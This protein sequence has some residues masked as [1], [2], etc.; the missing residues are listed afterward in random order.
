VVTYDEAKRRVNISKHGV[1]MSRLSGFFDGDLLTREDQREAYGEAR[2]QSIGLH[3]G[4]MLLVVWTP[5]NDE[6]PHIYFGA[7]GKKT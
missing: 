6:W 3:A 2:F 4:E 7:K 5:G 1:D